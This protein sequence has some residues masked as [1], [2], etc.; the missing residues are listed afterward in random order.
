MSIPAAFVLSVCL[1]LVIAI[2]SGLLAQFKEVKYVDTK[3]PWYTKLWFFFTMRPTMG[4]WFY[5]DGLPSSFFARFG[6]LFDG[7]KGPSQYIFVDQNDPNTIPKWTE[8]GHNGIGRMRAL[9]SDDSNE[10]IKIPSS[11]RLLGCTRSFYVVV[12]LLRRVSLGIISATYSSPKVSQSMFALIITL[13]Q[14]IYLFTLKPY[15]SRGVHVVESL[16]LLCEVGI[17]TLFITVKSTNPIEAHILGY[18]MLSLLFIAFVTQLI[19][20]WYGLINSLASL[21][22]PQKN[23]LKLGLKFAARGLILPFLPRKHWSRFIPASSQP[24]TGL[25]PV[26]PLSPEKETKRRDARAPGIDPISA[27]SAT[28]V[29]VLSPGSPG[30]NVN[31]TTGSATTETN[32]SMQ[33]VAEGKRLKGPKLEPKSD[34]KKLRELARASFSGDPKGDEASTS[35]GYRM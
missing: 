27:M 16:S 10:E 11:R 32:L 4:K 21:S 18:T 19:N 23:S 30:P 15:I 8:S 17:F 14:F 7:L 25:A 33:R 3:E 5:R 9:S 26:L 28:V 31:Q 24:K 1:F 22:Q 2:F 34:L 12:D 6:I 13:V 35:Y 20:E 29:P